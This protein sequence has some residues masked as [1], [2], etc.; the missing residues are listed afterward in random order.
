MMTKDIHPAFGNE[1]GTATAYMDLVDFQYELGLASDGNKV[2]PSVVAIVEDKL[3]CIAECG[4][5][6]VEIKLKRVILPY[7]EYKDREK[8]SAEE[9]K[10]LLDKRLEEVLKREENELAEDIRTL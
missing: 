10:S 3:F 8:L 2:Y 9:L 1:D 7:L 6:E 4:I 5:V